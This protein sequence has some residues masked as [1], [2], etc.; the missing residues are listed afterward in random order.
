M[1]LIITAND[2]ERISKDILL[3]H[4]EILAISIMDI[5]GNILASKSQESFKNAFILIHDEGNLEYAATLSVSILA[6][7]NKRRQVFQETKAIITVY[8]E[9]KIILLPL[10]SHHVLI[11]L[12][13]PRSVDVEDF[14]I[15]DKIGRLLLS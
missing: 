14:S 5:Y 7:S 6:L 1:S 10:P 13:F 4:D 2:A 8:E 11:E 12:I 3:E 9:C 15:A